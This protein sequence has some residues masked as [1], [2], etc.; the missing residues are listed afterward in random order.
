MIDFSIDSDTQQIVDAA[1]RYAQDILLPRQREFEA[2]R[3]IPEAVLEQACA[4][5]L[6]RARWK[7]EHGGSELNWSSWT[8]VLGELA[9]GDAAAAVATGAAGL[10]YDA[11]QLAAGDEWIAQFLTPERQATRQVLLVHDLHGTLAGYEAGRISGTL[12]WA[13]AA[14]ADV[15]VL[16]HPA[17]V[18]VL[19]QGFSLDAVPGLALQAAG[20]SQIRFADAPVAASRNDAALAQAALARA[21][22]YQASI[23]LGVLHAASAYAREYALQRVAFGKPIAHHQALAFLLVDM[24]SAVEQTRLL[25][26]EAAGRVDAGGP[27]LDVCNQAFIQACE[28]GHFI[29]PNAVQVLGAAGFMRDYPVEKYMRELTALGLALGGADA[30]RQSLCQHVAL[31]ESVEFLFAAKEGA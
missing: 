27:S 3:N 1:R 18:C 9:Q 5:G 13:N 2:S 6:D 22:L 4:M 25:V 12:P 26:Q 29:G 10:G 28:A 14:R 24:N 7:E 30:A 20:A 23:M 31:P 8:Q 21:R 17:G 11:L 15:L 16:V 19:T